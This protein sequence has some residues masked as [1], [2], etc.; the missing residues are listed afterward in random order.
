MENVKVKSGKGMAIASV[1]VLA[2][3]VI[4]LLLVGGFTLLA[5]CM[6]PPGAAGTPESALQVIAFFL[7]SIPLA[8][9]A[10]IFLSLI[11]ILILKEI[12]IR[13]KT[14]KLV[15]NLA[16]AAGLGGIASLFISF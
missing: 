16:V 4:G 8:A 11:L 15:I 3:D 12:F 5:N 7:F 1:V 13:A 6:V 2:I 10:G 14:A 9:C